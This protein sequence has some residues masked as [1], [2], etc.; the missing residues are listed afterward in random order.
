MVQFLSQQDYTLTNT[1]NFTYSEGLEDVVVVFTSVAET[2]P[3]NITTSISQDLRARNYETSSVTA[4]QPDCKYSVYHSDN[5]NN[6][7]METMWSLLNL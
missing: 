5:V 7:Y 4:F 3:E 1:S 6:S 2:P